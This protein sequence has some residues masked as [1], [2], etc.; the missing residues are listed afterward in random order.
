MQILA[1][2]MSHGQ[3]ITL[4]LLCVFLVLFIVADVFM[5][6]SLRKSNKELAK[7]VELQE[8]EKAKEDQISY[9]E[10]SEKS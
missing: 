1:S 3:A 4:T 10:D 2:S 7:K 5:V 6:L 8:A 9:I